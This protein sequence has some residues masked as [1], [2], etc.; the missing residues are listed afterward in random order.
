M[1]LIELVQLGTGLGVFSG[2]LGIAKW[3]LGVERRL[4]K[5]EVKARIEK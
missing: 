5:L 2:G 4:F 3:A 1:S